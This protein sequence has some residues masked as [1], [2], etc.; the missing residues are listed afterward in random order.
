M[1]TES[2]GEQTLEQFFADVGVPHHIHSDNAQMQRSKAWKDILRKY[3]T[4]S[5]T[6]EPHH[7]QQ[8]PAERR[9]QEIKKHASSILDHTGAPNYLWLYAILYVTFL[10]NHMA[11]KSLDWKTPTEVAFGHTPDISCLLQYEFYEK[12]YYSNSDQSFPESKEMLGWWL[13]IAE[14]VGDAMTYWILTESG[15]VL[16]RSVLRSAHHTKDKNERADG[17]SSD[18]DPMP[19]KETAGATTFPLQHLDTVFDSDMMP[20]DSRPVTIEETPLL[21]STLDLTGNNELPNVDPLDL[22]GYSFVDVVDGLQRKATVKEMTKEGLF[23]IE[24]MNG[25]REL[26]T[27][28]DLINQYNA[29]TEDGADFWTF[30]EIIGHRKTKTRGYEMQVRWDTGEITWEPATSVKEDDPVT[31]AKYAHDAKLTEERGWKWTKRYTKNPKNFIR[32]AKIFKAQA[33]N[34]GPKYKFGI[35]VPRTVKEAMEIDRA[36]GNTLW[37]EAIDKEIGQL[38]DFDTF[39]ALPKGETAPAGWTRVPLHMCF[40]AK[41]DARRKARLVAGGNWTEPGDEDVYSGVVSIDTIRCGLFLAQLNGLEVT[42]ADIGNAYL[43]GVTREKVY[44]IAGPEFGPLQGHC[45][46]VRK[47]IYGLRTS[48]ARWHEALSDTLKRMG[49]AP[50]YADPNMWIKDAGDHYEY[51]ATWVDDLLVIGHNTMETIEKFKELYPLKG[52]GKPEYYLGGDVEEVEVDGKK[53]W[54]LSAKTCL[55]NVCDKI[56]RLYEVKLRNYGSPLEAG[57]HPEIDETPLLSPNEV[58]KYRMLIGCAQWAVTLGR[59]DVMFAVSTMARYSAAP[60]EGHLKTMLRA[61]GY[62]KHYCRGRIVFDTREPEHKNVEKLEHNWEE[63]YPNAS[64]EMPPNMPEPKGNAVHIDTWFDADHAHDL[65]TRRSVTGVLVFLNSTPVKWYSKRQNTVESSTYG[66]ELM[67]ARI[68][69]DLTVEMRYK[70]RMLGAPIAGPTMMF[71]DNQSVMINTSL[72]SSTLK[73]K[74]CSIAYHRVR[75]AVAAGIIEP[76]HIP[77]IENVSDTLTKALGPQVVYRLCKGRLF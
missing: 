54:A 20:D 50:S 9:I 76:H 51:I 57:Y 41:F 27:Y 59:Y 18:S 32:L 12:V 66:S 42:A 33:R 56:E 3:N 31:L 6:T 22:L 14:N 63:L 30:D 34:N 72:P 65:E 4:S 68:A 36:E 62:L 60:R 35:R 70:M 11:T 21:A 28:N 2:Q 73:K 58:T 37:K 39:E 13:G 10:L 25:T 1:A 69:T 15:Q 55:K 74:N 53:A 48:S 52:V 71:G 43:H 7:P 24:F 45:M 19:S 17:S 61:F 46:L 64:E 44:C 67:A 5:S 29:R 26:R 8:N 47:S 40:D 49:Y 23:A 77:G 75:E 38:L 16:A